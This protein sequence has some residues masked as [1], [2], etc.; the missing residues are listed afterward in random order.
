MDAAGLIDNWWKRVSANST[1]CLNKLERETNEKKT[2]DHKPL[3]LKSLSGAFVLLGA[4]YALAITAF[5]F[6]IC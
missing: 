1:Y 4:G 6:E 3:T 2:N 5:L